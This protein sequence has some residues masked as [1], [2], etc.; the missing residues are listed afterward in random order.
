[1][2]TE[3]HMIRDIDYKVCSFAR[4]IVSEAEKR[5]IEA[6][7]YNTCARSLMHEPN[8]KATWMKAERDVSAVLNSHSDIIAFYDVVIDGTDYGD[9]LAQKSGSYEE[10]R[11]KYA[12]L[13]GKDAPEMTEREFLVRQNVKDAGQVYVNIE[14]RYVG[15]LASVV[16]G[17]DF[18]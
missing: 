5:S 12:A 10:Y 4:D 8:V 11:L 18:S 14:I 3:E 6:E 7:A 2:E 15:D 16:I 17:C 13:Y 9:K 1:M